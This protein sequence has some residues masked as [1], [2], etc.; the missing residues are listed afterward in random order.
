VCGQ[1]VGIAVDVYNVSGLRGGF[2]ISRTQMR[3]KGRKENSK[4]STVME[5]GS[6]HLSKYNQYNKTHLLLNLNPQLRTAD[7]VECKHEK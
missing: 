4:V 3:Q 5:T 1:S 7:I 6:V 2:R